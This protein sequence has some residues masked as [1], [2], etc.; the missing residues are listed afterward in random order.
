MKTF[1]VGEIA[2]INNI[3]LITILTLVKMW[4]VS[5]QSHFENQFSKEEWDKN[6]NVLLNKKLIESIPDNKAYSITDSGL[7]LLQKIND[8]LVV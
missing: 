1:N 6:I 8:L 7:E 4:I 3:Q 2:L 5:P